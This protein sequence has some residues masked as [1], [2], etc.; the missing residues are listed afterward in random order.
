V[1]RKNYNTTK[2]GISTVCRIFQSFKVAK[3]NVHQQHDPKT[4]WFNKTRYGAKRCGVNFLGEETTSKRI[5]EKIVF[6]KT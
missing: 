5:V 1:E 3:M 4:G 2:R 6:L